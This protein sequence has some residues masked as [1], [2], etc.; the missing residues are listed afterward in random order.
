MIVDATGCTIRREEDILADLVTGYQTIYGSDIAITPD[1]QD[2][3]M[4]ALIAAM[5]ADLENK[6]LLV[7]NNQNP[8]G[9]TGNGLALLVKLNGLTKQSLSYSTAVITIVG[10]VGTVI[11][12]PIVSDGVNQWAYSGSFTI[13]AAGQ[14]DK[15]F[16]CIT[17]GAIVALAHAINQIITPVVGWQTC[18]NAAA[19]TVGNQ[20][21]TDAVL[22]IRRALSVALPSITIAD[23]ILAYILNLANVVQAKL[24]EN[25]TDVVDGNGLPPH[26]IAL[27]VQGGNDNDIANVL[28]VKRT[29]GCDM[30]GSTTVDITDSQGTITTYKFNRPTQTAIKIQI[31]GD[32]R[33]G[34]QATTE[35]LIK[36]AL[37][38][39]FTNYSIGK[40]ATPSQLYVPAQYNNPDTFDITLI[41]VAKKTD[42]FPGT[43]APLV[44]AYNEQW[45]L[46][47]GD[48]TVNIT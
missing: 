21:E 43:Q 33:T 16:T 28:A 34:W 8:N 48:I 2:G 10:V 23:G 38:T 39:Y 24:Y 20:I 32:Q 19:A 5:V 42:P 15:T 47:T 36:D 12:N 3:Q 27:I 35:D 13:P 9:A 4:L 29:E 45:T 14:I 11:T 17:A 1:T 40:A 6:G 37:V 31:T 46:A 26:S 44:A 41:E 18:D 22:R 30:V 7:Y 25:Y